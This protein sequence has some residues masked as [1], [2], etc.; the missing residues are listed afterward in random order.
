M[1]EREK[2]EITLDDLALMMGRGFDA[3]DKRFDA[4]DK[5]LGAVE[6]GVSNLE[7][8]MREVKQ[9]LDKLEDKIAELVGTLDAFLK[10]LTDREEEFTLLKREMG[11]VKKV[12]Q[13]KLHVDVDSLK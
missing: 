7:I 5:R 2:K 12:L 10:R 8:D 11:I 1:A 4:V 6:V 3:V 13:E 9:R